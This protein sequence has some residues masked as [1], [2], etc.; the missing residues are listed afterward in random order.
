MKIK[1]F[2]DQKHL[3]QGAIYKAIGRAGYS[4]RQLT[5]KKGNITTKGM[6]IINKLFADDPEPDSEPLK[7]E[8]PED[9]IIAELRDRLKEAKERAEKWETRYLELQTKTEQ[10]RAS[11]LD[12]ISEANRLLSQQQE[13]ERLRAMN[14]IKRLFSGRKK[15]QQQIPSDGQ[16]H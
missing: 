6:A 5:D 16:I 12:K 2:A 14:P 3:T 1:E 15:E 10:E 4:A 9:I 11:L 7:E 13:L 8:K